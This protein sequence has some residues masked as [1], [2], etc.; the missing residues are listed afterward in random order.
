MTLLFSS[1]LPSFFVFS[2]ARSWTWHMASALLLGQI[3]SLILFFLFKDFFI[4]VLCICFTCMH[5]C[6][7]HV[8][9]CLLLVCLSHVCVCLLD[10]FVPVKCLYACW[11]CGSFKCVCIAIRCLCVCHV[12]VPVTCVCACWMCVCLS[13]VC[14]AGGSQKKAWCPVGS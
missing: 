10:M 12:C 9:V 3:L 2:S 6:L 7:F 13:H 14:S 5:A 8:F 1:F 4:F 11:M